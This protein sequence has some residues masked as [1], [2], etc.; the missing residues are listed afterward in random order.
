MRLAAAGPVYRC[1]RN[2]SRRCGRRDLAA[3]A[4]AIRRLAFLDTREPWP[5]DRATL[6]VDIAKPTPAEQRALW[7]AALGADHA[8][9][10]DRPA[11]HFDFGA[12]AIRAAAGAALA[13]AQ[14]DA[15][16]LPA[17]LWTQCIA[18]ARP[19]LDQLVPAGRSE[20][21]L[22]RSGAAAGREGAAAPDRRPGGASRHGLRRLGLSRAHEP[23]SRH[24]RVVRGRE[25]HRQDDGRGG[26]RQRTRPAALSHR[27]VRRGQQ[28]HRRDRKKICVACSTRPKAVARSC[29]ST[30]PTRCSASAAK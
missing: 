16:A 27:S 17:L 9:A 14:G 12:N 28:V 6:P 7:N 23:R 11:V 24:Q 22:G 3:R 20:G 4:R 26:H 19:V 13:L 21:A 8:A 15:H 29:C 1:A 18:G 2:R 10:A 25:R 5:L 30:R